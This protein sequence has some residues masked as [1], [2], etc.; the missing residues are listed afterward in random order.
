MSVS[1]SGKLEWTE[2]TPDGIYDTTVTTT[3]G[4]FTDTHTLTLAESEDP[5]PVKDEGAEPESIE[6]SPKT[7]TFIDIWEPYT[8]K[9]FNVTILPESADQ[10][11]TVESSDPTVIRARID[12]TQAVAEAIKPGTADLT[13]KTVDGLT[14]TATITVP[15]QK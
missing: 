7:H 3:N 5:D 15:E 2:D 8:A 1:S 4:G 14:A 11:F 10:T 12:G 6:V 9:R 13:V